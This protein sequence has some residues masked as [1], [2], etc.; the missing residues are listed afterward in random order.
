MFSKNTFLEIKAPCFRILSIHE[1]F[2]WFLYSD[3]PLSL[4]V[5]YILKR[6]IEFDEIEIAENSECQINK[7]KD[8]F[9][10]AKSI[11]DNCLRYISN[12]WL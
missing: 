4:R 7:V 8:R 9:Q 11:P 1:K 3:M 10:K 5:I 12:S 6:T 2:T